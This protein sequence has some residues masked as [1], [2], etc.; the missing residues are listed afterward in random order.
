MPK[1]PNWTGKKKKRF[2]FAITPLKLLV[3]QEISSI[4]QISPN[5]LLQL[6]HLISVSPS[7]Q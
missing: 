7:N 2:Q 6:C 3:D 1:G 4:E 5:D